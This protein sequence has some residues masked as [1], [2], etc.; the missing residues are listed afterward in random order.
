M[1]KTIEIDEKV[2]LG[3]QLQQQDVGAVIVINTFT[4]NSDH[5]DQ[6]L[7]VWASASEIAKKAIPGAISIR[8]LRGIAGSRVFVGYYVFK[9]TEAIMQLYRNPDF[10][11]KLSYIDSPIQES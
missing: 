11:T 5:V 8:L 3:T 10:P 2:N 9:S 4:I 7:R 1:V 6:F